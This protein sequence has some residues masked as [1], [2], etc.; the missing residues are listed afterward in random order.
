MPTIDVPIRCVNA[1][2]YT[3]PTEHPEADATLCWDRTTLIAVHIDAANMR[4]FGYTYGTAALTPLIED[5]LTP[6]LL[7]R[8]ALAIPARWHDMRAALRNVGLPGAGA[9]AVS[10]LD[11]ALWDLKARLLD[12]PLSTLLGSA[13]EEVPIY[14]SGG[15]TSDTDAELEDQLRHWLDDLECRFV[16]IKI[17]P[18]TTR[19]VERMTLARDIAAP[20][21]LMVDSNGGYTPKQALLVAELLADLG[22]SWLEEPVSSDDLTGLAAL[23]DRV[24]A[25][26]EIA[27][28]EYAHDPLEIKALIDA[29]AVDTVQIDVTRCCGVTGF[30]RAAAIAE[31]AHTPISTHTAPALHLHV[32]C[33]TPMLRHVEWFHDHARI[34]QMLFD[35][36]PRPTHGQIRPDLSR[37][38]HGLEFKRA[39]AERFAC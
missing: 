29:S 38:G 17:G 37:P 30:L 12:L 8:D 20:A 39:D 11:A 33:A 22:G 4:G 28:G 7:E 35:G 14:G 2:A 32:A 3:I 16:K 34:E 10:A 25:P 9:M 13:R 21:E 23:R 19:D 27:A 24:P 18:D 6:I 1:R 36:A 31:A 15:F 26:V 5:T